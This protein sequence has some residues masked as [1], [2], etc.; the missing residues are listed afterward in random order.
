MAIYNHSS[1]PVFARFFE[2]VLHAYPQSSKAYDCIQLT[3][4]DFLEMG[5]QRCLSDSKTGRDFVQRHGDHGR[6]EISVDLF[7]KALKSSRRLENTQSINQMIAPLMT[8]R[9]QDPFAGIAELDEFSIYAGDGHFHGAACHDA[10]TE[11]SQGVMTKRAT[12]H[13][14]MLNLRT[15]HLVHLALAE[16]GGLRKGEHDMR[17]IKRTETDVLRGGAPKGQKVIIAWDRAGIDF[18]Y[19]AQVKASAGLYFISREKENMKLIKCGAKP[20]DAGDVRNAGVIADELVGPGSGGHML[21]RITYIDPLEGTRYTYI[22]TQMTLPPGL[23]VLLYKQRWDIEKVFDELKS[24]LYEMKSWASSPVAKSMHAQFLCL[25]HN[26]MV[27]LEEEIVGREGVDNARERNRKDERMKRAQENGANF[28]ATA[29][30]RFTVRSLKFIRWLRNFVY[31]EALWHHAL[32][33]LS[34]IYALF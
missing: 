14:F 2:P 4:L 26:L 11:S 16:K 24:K 18:A 10:K 7:F 21:R 5:I 3:D 6:K 1:S 31:R 22:T 32:K 27:F 12:G 25:V 29:L 13:F 8:E 20:F 30:Q 28:I 15:H 33:R 17:A 34:Q 19:W 9:C 23:L